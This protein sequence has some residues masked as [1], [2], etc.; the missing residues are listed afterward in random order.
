MLAR[1]ADATVAVAL[2]KSRVLY[3]PGGRNLEGLPG[4]RI[5]RDRQ[6]ARF[7]GPDEFLVLCGVEY[8]VFEKRTRAARVF[9]SFDDQHRF[10]QADLADRFA[11]LRQR[12]MRRVLK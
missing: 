2:V 10:R 1:D 6:S 12:W 4:S 11:H 9:V 8:R 7:R 3:Q 5:G